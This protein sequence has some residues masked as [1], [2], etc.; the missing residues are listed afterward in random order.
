MSARAL[1]RMVIR[2]SVKLPPVTRR[3]DPWH[4]KSMSSTVN[5]PPVIVDTIGLCSGPV[6]S[7]RV[8]PGPPTLQMVRVWSKSISLSPLS[9]KV[10]AFRQMVSLSDPPV[11]VEMID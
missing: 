5:E 1:S 2:S 7:I 6:I 4:W 3:H 8:V 9:A 11:M 10:P